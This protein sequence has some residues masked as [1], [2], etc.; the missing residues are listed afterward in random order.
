MTERII[1]KSREIT[2][3]KKRKA[4]ETRKMRKRKRETK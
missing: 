2:C 3:G 4:K 1:E